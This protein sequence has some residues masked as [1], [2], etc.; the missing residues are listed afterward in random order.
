MSTIGR[1]N[2]PLLGPQALPPTPAASGQTPSPRAPWLWLFLRSQSTRKVENC[3][4][5]WGDL[6]GP[7][8]K[9]GGEKE[10]ETL[11]LLG[12]VLKEPGWFGG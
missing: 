6:E 4:L 1:E 9:V 11:P 12:S 5:G 2:L 3:C 8:G 10:T 7:R